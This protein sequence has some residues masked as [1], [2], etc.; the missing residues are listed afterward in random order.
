[1]QKQLAILHMHEQILKFSQT[2]NLKPLHYA[3]KLGSHGYLAAVDGLQR[4]TTT[5]FQPTQGKPAVAQAYD[6]HL[7]FYTA[8]TCENEKNIR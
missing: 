5:T 6:M 2:T 1:M 4:Q 8:I 3:Y 7:F